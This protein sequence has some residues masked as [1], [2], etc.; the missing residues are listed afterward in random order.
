M[1]VSVRIG[2]MVF[3]WAKFDPGRE[4]FAPFA[5]DLV[6]DPEERKN[7]FD[8][9]D[10]HHQEVMDKLKAYKRALVST[11]YQ[12]YSTRGPGI[13]EDERIRRLRSLGYI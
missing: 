8:H 4:D 11:C 13:P 12:K 2:N 3:K 10:K 1:W 6:N 7:L 5:F 9:K